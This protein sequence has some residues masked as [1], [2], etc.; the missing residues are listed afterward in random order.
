MSEWFSTFIENIREL[1]AVTW[2]LLAVLIVLGIAL[3]ILRRKNARNSV[4]IAVVGIA[5]AIFV[6]LV[7]FLAPP[8]EESGGSF[9][10]TPLFW[11]IVAAVLGLIALYMILARQKFTTRMLSNGALAVAIAFL[12]SCLILYRMPQGGSVTL[13]SM[14]PILAYAVAYG[15]A[16]GT[17]AGTVYGALQLIQGAYVIHP[18]QLLLDYILPFACLGIAGFF[19]KVKWM[20]VGATVAT[21]AR[22]AVHVISGAVFFAEYAPVGMNAWVYSMG[23]NASFLIPELLITIVILLLPPVQKAIAQMAEGVRKSENK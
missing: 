2:A 3:I 12:L 10:Y 7:V 20:P 23:Y 18:I 17:A 9:F 16:A 15:P 13:A 1:P 5:A 8:S 22:W 19:R 11:G 14:V 4:L 6:V 21:I